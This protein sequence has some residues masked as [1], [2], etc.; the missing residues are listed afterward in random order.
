M[1][2]YC[3]NTAIFQGWGMLSG[4]F[5]DCLIVGKANSFKLYVENSVDNV[6]NILRFCLK[7]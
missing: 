3:F 2:L 4:M 5:T 7:P 1:S 6:E